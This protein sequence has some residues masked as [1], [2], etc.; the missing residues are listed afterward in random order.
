MNTCTRALAALS[1]MLL[2]VHAAAV[3][4]LKN[5][6]PM[7]HQNADNST[8]NAG[9]IVEASTS[10]PVLIIAGGFTITCSSS[11]LP[12]TAERRATFTGFFGINESLRVPEVLPSTYAI[13]GYTNIPIGSC[14]QCV[15]QYKGEARD[16][17]S[18]SVR[19]GNQG[20]GASFTLIPAGEQLI[21]NAQLIEVCR[22]RQRQCCTPLCSIP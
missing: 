4:T 14:G 11:S 12:Q 2:S 10:L 3:P 9:L 21:G 6:T 5:V 15:M 13:P 16:E 17:T 18:L 19:V 22:L 8:L 20:V 1:L 7:F